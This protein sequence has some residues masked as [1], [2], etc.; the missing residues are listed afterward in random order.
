M[1]FRR[2]RTEYD[3]DRGAGNRKALAGLVR[4]GA[5]TGL[6]AYVGKVPVGWCAVAPRRDYTALER[7][8]LFKPIDDLPVWSVTCFY[9][10]RGW[11]RR[12]VTL[13]LLEAAVAWARKKRAKAI[14]GYPVVP[15]SGQAPEVYIYQGTMSTFEKAGF[16][17]VKR[18]APGRAYMRLT[19]DA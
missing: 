3:Q 12:G 5:P 17:V 6:L 1:F 18:P 7:S 13:A 15:K 8:R 2:T 4:R 10:A 9:V 14:E 11:R 16:E 19:L